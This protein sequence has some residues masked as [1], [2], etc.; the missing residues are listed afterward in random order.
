MTTR[1]SIALILSPAGLLLIS[2]GRLIIVANFNTTTAVT[3]A[4]SGG[5]VNTLLGTVIPLVPV[6]MPYLALLLLLF[7]RFLLSIMTFIFAAFISPTS[8]TLAE[9]FGLARTDWN[10]TTAVVANHRIIAIVIVL[11]ILAALWFYNRS[12]VEGLSVVVVMVAALTLL[13][14]IPIQYLSLPLGLA[15]SNE[16]RLVTRAASGAYWY[17]WREILAALV[18]LAIVFIALTSPR[19]LSGLVVRFSWLL[20]SVVAVI[21]TIAFF[22]YVHFI[23]PVP[24]NHP[25][26]A[27]VT[28]TMWLPAERI[29]LKSHLVYYG[30]VLSSD[31]RW[32]TVLLDNSRVIAYLSAG[33]VMG[34]SVCQPRMRPQPKQPRMQPQ[35]EQLPPLI[36]W[37]YHPPRSLPPCSSQDEIALITSFLSRG[38][39][40][41]EISSIIHV[42]PGRIIC[43]TNA[44]QHG[45]LSAALRAYECR[46]DWNA[47]T[48]VGQHF[49]YYPS[50]VPY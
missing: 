13:I 45:L 50:I 5:F 12:F 31:T 40:L 39:S 20:T 11:A 47:P 25:Y 2:A 24:Q 7:R 38:E 42:Q 3:I 41:R 44:Y 32:F 18:I 4:S 30:Y 14:A 48:P 35:P 19:T 34:R 28:H 23:Y 37:L 46:H 29:E 8:I 43:I 21:A 49:W 16:H 15:S 22:P 33:D 17:P 36:P 6:F 1:R 27:E 26:Y 9:G 10:R